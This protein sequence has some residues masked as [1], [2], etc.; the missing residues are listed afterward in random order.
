MHEPV[1]TSGAREPF[2]LQ[3]GGAHFR[4]GVVEPRE[5]PQS[6]GDRYTGAITVV[7]GEMHQATVVHPKPR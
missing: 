1:K 7:R 6:F 3:A 4:R 2:E 5:G